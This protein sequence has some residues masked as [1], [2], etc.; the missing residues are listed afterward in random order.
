MFGRKKR[1]YVLEQKVI[2][3]GPPTQIY[4]AK[5]AYNPSH[6]GAV[7]MESGERVQ[8][9]GP[10]PGTNSKDWTCIRRSTGAQ[11]FVPTS[12]IAITQSQPQLLQGV[13][14]LSRTEVGLAAPRSIQPPT[15]LVTYILPLSGRFGG[16]AAYLR[17][18]PERAAASGN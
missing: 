5:A 11:G 9:V 4:T 16:L 3:K 8:Y 12:F 7:P 6:A 10:A 18:P 14:H 17:Q 2:A 15:V 1:D 13:L